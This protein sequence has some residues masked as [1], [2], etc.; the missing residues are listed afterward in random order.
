QSNHRRSA[1]F[2]GVYPLLLA[3]IVKAE[4]SAPPPPR[5]ALLNRFIVLLE[6]QVDQKVSNS[7]G[8]NGFGCFIGIIR[9]AAVD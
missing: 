8:F 5:V 7:V 4:R 2:C 9:R 6:M 1:K 3:Q